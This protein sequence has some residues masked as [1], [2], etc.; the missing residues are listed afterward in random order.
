MSSSSRLL[1]FIVLSLALLVL[2]LSV[3]AAS[4]AL[5]AIASLPLASPL[6][7][8]LPTP[9]TIPGSISASTPVSKQDKTGA[10]IQLNLTN[11]S[12]FIGA[13]VVV[14]WQDSQ[15]QWHDVPGWRNMLG[16]KM[17][18]WW[19]SPKDFGAGPFRWLVI[20]KKVIVAQ[21]QPFSLPK[22]ASITLTVRAT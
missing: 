3:F 1:R 9:I 13:T 5:P 14:Q 15:K 16:A 4:A 20:R 2:P 19:V 8:P 17:L 11:A 18:K 12:R 10:Y 21:S 6:N 22:N 7:S